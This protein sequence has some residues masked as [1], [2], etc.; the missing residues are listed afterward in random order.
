MPSLGSVTEGMLG[1]QL[2]LQN[3]QLNQYKIAEAPIQLATEQI[4][5]Q[6]EQIAL[7]QQVH[8]LSLMQNLKPPSD[9][10]SPDGIAAVLNQVAGYYLQS[11]MPDAAAKMAKEA[12]SIQENASKIDARAYKMQNDRLSKFANILDGAPDSPGGWAAAIQQMV[13]ED[14]AVAKDSRFVQLAQQPWRPGM[15][16]GIKNG[17]LTLKEQAEVDYRKKAAAHADMAAKL[18]KARIPLIDAQ[19]Q[20]ARDRDKA[21]KK[22][23]GIPVKASQL[24]VITDLADAEYPGSDPADVRNR[25][26]PLAEEMVK[27][28]RDEG[29]T[30]SQAG[31]RVYEQARSQGIFTGLRKAPVPK[32]AAP[33]KGLQLPKTA[34]QVQEN[35]WYDGSQFPDG[36]ARVAMG[37]K[38]YTEEELA[39][40]GLS[41]PNKSADDYELGPEE[42]EDEED[43]RP[44]Q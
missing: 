9:A 6:K 24:K 32:G 31:R 40:A 34:K 37:G 8:M 29:L 16:Q 13:A 11:G 43:T 19:T 20:L 33:G 5:L 2:D 7:R 4:N 26:R 12:S 3:I 14:P 36:Q 30:E 35:Q 27:M 22:D 41:D 15:M 17:V 28:M 38:F 42:E 21:I 44:A 18:D 39:E 1:A 25:S 23:G 10:N